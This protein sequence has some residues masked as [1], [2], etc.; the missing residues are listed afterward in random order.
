MMQ[1]LVDELR[2]LPRDFVVLAIMP[3]KRFEAANMR[4]LKYLVDDLGYHGAYIAM[5]KPYHNVSKIMQQNNID[6][7]KVLFID[8]VTGQKAKAQNAVFLNSMES[9][10]Q[11]GICLDPVYKNKDLSFVFLDSLDALSV[12]HDQRMVLRFVRNMIERVREHQKSGVVLG[13]HEQTDK[14][15]VDELAVVCDK[16]INLSDEQ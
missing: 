13:V 7:N 16:V 2:G 4:L 9:L 3:E 14:R 5:N 11:I 8:C 1:K 6:H 15:I 12:Y 10:T